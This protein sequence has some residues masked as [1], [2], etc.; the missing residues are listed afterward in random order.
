MPV[1]TTTASAV[2]HYYGTNCGAT[3]PIFD[4]CISD[5]L[6]A[7]T[8]QNYATIE[9]WCASEQTKG[10]GYWYMCL[11]G[12][13]QKVVTCYNTNCQS[14]ATFQQAVT[15]QTSYCDAMKQFVTWTTTT[16]KPWTAPAPT[17]LIGDAGMGPTLAVNGTKQNSAS[18]A[19]SVE[20]AAGLALG[21]LF[22]L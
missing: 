9:T 13:S 11:C 21:A 6:Y 22:I 16:V 7:S 3:Q 17:D 2:S 8:G 10:Q 1:P 15:S 4:K 14:D 18:G 19:G 20:F 12:Q 5:L